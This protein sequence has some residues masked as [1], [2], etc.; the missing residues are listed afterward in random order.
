MSAFDIGYMGRRL[1]SSFQTGGNISR[2]D[3]VRVC[4]V[5]N[6]GDHYVKAERILPDERIFPDGEPQFGNIACVRDGDYVYMVSGHGLE[7]VLARARHDADFTKRSEYQFWCKGD[8]WQDDFKNVD[9]LQPLLGWLGQGQIVA[10]PGCGPGGKRLMLFCNEK[11]PTGFIFMGWAD[12]VEGPWDV[13]KIGE[14]PKHW[15]NSTKSRYAMFPHTW[16]YDWNEGEMLMTYSDDGQMGGAVLGMK[17]TF[18]VE[19]PPES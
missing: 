10:T 4:R 17:L 11:W 19:R 1:T 15:P 6:T 7:N 2:S 16:C 3:G 14:A 13:V 9:E 18:E 5:E 8:Q 12:K